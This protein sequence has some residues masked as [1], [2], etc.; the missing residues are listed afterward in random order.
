MRGASRRRRFLAQNTSGGV[1][2]RTRP[3]CPYPQTAIYNGTGSIDDAASFHCGGDLETP[4][5]VCADVLAQYK[6]E[7]T[8]P[9][10]SGVRRHAP[11]VRG[12]RPVAAR[13]ATAVA[14]HFKGAGPTAPRS[15]A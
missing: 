12:D 15:A 4:D 14:R 11:D 5:V 3:R 6:H 7:T 9:L 2:T 10:S 13:A 1:V 8:G